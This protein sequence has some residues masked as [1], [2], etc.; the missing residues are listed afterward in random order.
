MPL[1][2]HIAC[3]V[4]T[5]AVAVGLPATLW[6]EP[7]TAWIGASVVRRKVTLRRG[8]DGGLERTAASQFQW[9]PPLIVVLPL[10]VLWADVRVWVPLP[11]LTNESEPPE[12]LMTPP[13]VP[14]ALLSPI[15][16]VGAPFAPSM[17]PE[18]LRP[19]IVVLNPP[20]F[21]LPL[22]VTSPGEA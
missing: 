17:A 22:S 15:V 19:L 14:E 13:N 16:K 11:I 1:L 10:Y 21:K 8:I 4:A 20:R 9:F 6:P 5:P 2:N 12:F 7:S 3:A 18:P